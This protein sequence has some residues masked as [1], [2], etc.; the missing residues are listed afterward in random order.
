VSRVSAPRARRYGLFSRPRNIRPVAPPSTLRRRLPSLEALE[1]RRV[2]ANFSIGDAMIDEG[3]A[4]TT[5][6]RFTVTLAEPN[7]SPVSVN[8]QTA[9]GTAQSGGDDTDF[10]GNTGTLTFPVGVTTQFIDVAINGDL[11][12][13]ANETFT[14]ML[15]GPT[16]GATISDDTATGTITNDDAA[17]VKIGHLPVN[18]GNTNRDIE[19]IITLS[20]PVD[21]PVTVDYET[22]PITATDTGPDRDYI[23]E[24]GV[25]TFAAGDTLERIP[26][27]IVG[28]T[29][30]EQNESF[31][32]RMSNIQPTSRSVTFEN[33]AGT[34]TLFN[35]EGTPPAATLSINDVTETEGH[36]GTRNLQFTV[37]LANH[38]GGL[39]IL[40]NYTTQDQT[41]TAADNDY[42]TATGTLTFF[43]G[44]PLTQTVNVT[45]NGDTKVEAGT[46]TFNVVLANASLGV[47]IADDTG[48]GTITDDD[49]AEITISDV[50]A[51]EG[52]TGQTAFSF[53][54]ALSNPVDVAVSGSYATQNG[55]AE[56]QTGDND[57]VSESGTFTFAPGE[58]ETFIVV[59]VN[60]DTAVEPTENFSVVLS[61]L[62]TG[63]RNV[64][65]T[66]ATGTGTITSDDIGLTA[67]LTIDDVTQAESN[68]NYVFTLSL[69]APVAN[70]VCVDVTTPA[71]MSNVCIP[72]TATSATVTVNRPNDD[73]V[74][75]DET[76]QV[77]LGTVTV[78]GSQVTITDPT[79]VGT[80]EDD[81]T[82]TIT[83]NDVSVAEGDTGDATMTFTV[84]LSNPVSA[85]VTMT[86]TTL[87]GGAQD[88]TGDNDYQSQS[89]ALTIPAMSLSGTINIA[90]HGDMKVERDET[91][92][93]QLGVLTAG[94]FEG[95]EVNIVDS[96]GLGMITNDD[97]ATLSIDDVSQSESIE[98]YEFTLTLS[99]PVDTAITV[100]VMTDLD[101]TPITFAAGETTQTVLVNVPDNDIVE[102]DGEFEVTLANLQANGRN[103][104][105]SDGMGLGTILDDDAATI[106][107]N[108]VEQSES[109]ED[110]EFTI[111]LSQAVDTLVCVDV[112]T[113]LDM[114]DICFDPLETSTTFTVNVPDND[115]VEFDGFFDVTL[116]NVDAGGLPVT[117]LDGMGEG[118]ILDDDTAD[119]TIGD[120]MIVEGNSG[121]SML[122][123]TVMLSQEVDAIVTVTANTGG[124][125]A[126]AGTDYTAL[127]N[128]TI[129]F[130]ALSTSQTVSVPIQGDTATEPDETFIV[131]L[132]NL[133]AEGLEG[134]AVAI[135]DA[136]ATGTITNDD[137]GPALSINDVSVVEGNTGTTNLVFTVTLANADPQATVTV[138]VSTTDGTATTADNDYTAITAQTITFNPG[139]TT[140]QVNVAV[141]GDNRVEA[142]ETFTI[143][144][145]DATGAAVADAT[146]TGTITNDDAASI[147]ISDVSLAEGNSGTTTF[148]FTVTLNGPVDVPVTVTAN[149]ADGTALVA[150]NDYAALANS[151]ITFAAG[152][153]SQSVPVSVMGDIMPEANETFDVVLSNPQA[154]GRTVTLADATAMGTI[155]N[156]DAEQ[157]I[158]VVG[159]ATIVEG[160]TGTTMLTFT[161]TLMFPEEGTVTV[162]YATQDGTATTA[163]DDYESATGSL[164]LSST[165]P[166]AT[167][168]VTINGD[169]KIEVDETLQIMLSG[170]VGAVIGDATG[171]GTI[172]N[173]DD[174]VVS[175]AD[176]T[177][178]E[179]T[180]GT[181]TAMNF[182]VSLSQALTSDVT[183]TV[184]TADGTATLADTDY[185]ALTNQMV[186]IPAG[187]TSVPVTVNL[188]ADSRVEADEN[189]TVTLSNL[190]VGGAAD[191]NVNLGNATATGTITNDDNATISINDVTQLESVEDYTF[192]ITMSQPVDVAVTVD[193]MTDLGSMPITFAP[194]ETTQTVVVTVDDNDIVEPDGEF[195]VDLVNLQAAGRAVTI[196]DGEGVGTI[197]DDDTATL[198]INNVMQEESMEDYEFTLTLSKMVDAEVCVMVMTELDEVQVCFDPLDT[199]ETF[200][201]NIPDNDIVD[202]DG[203]FEVELA[204]LT[205]EGLP[206]TIAD[207]LGEGVILDDDTAV[208]SIDNVSVTEGNTGEEDMTFTLTL[209][210]PASETVT[211]T[212]MTVEGTAEDESGDNDF[213]SATGTVTFLPLETTA[214]IVLDA[215]G[216][217][218]IEPNETYTVVLSNIV[219]GDIR[220]DAITLSTTAGT[221]TGTILNDDSP[222]LSI[223]DATIVE[224]NSATSNLQ[225]TVTLSAAVS[226]DV[227]FDIATANGTAMSTDNDFTAVATTPLTIPAGQTTRTF[228][229]T[230]TGDTK[231]EATEN[232]TVNISNATNATIL[233]GAGTGT[234]TND[235]SAT[236]S[237]ADANVTEGN[238]GNA[239]MTFNVTLSNAVDRP[240]TITVNT[241]NGTATV[242][243]NDYTAITAGTVT[244]PAGQTTGTVT[245]NAT[246]DTRAEANENFTVTLSAPLV[247]GV[248]DTSVTLLD[249]TATGTINNDDAATVS[250]ADANVTEGNTGTATLSFT[251]TLSNALEQNVTMTVN[252][253]DGT[254]T[255]AGTASDYT[256]IVAGTATIP[257]GQTTAT[258]TVTV[259]GDTRVEANETLN[260]TLTN[261]L[262]GGV[263]NTGVTFSDASAIGTINND[264][265]ASLSIADLTLNEGTGT[266]QT[267]FTF[268]ITTTNPAQENITVQVSTTDGTATVAGTDYTAVTSQL[269][270]I[271]AGQTMT[272][273]TVN[274]TADSTVE[275]NE[276]FTV[277]LSNAQIGGATDATRVTI[278]DATAT[279]TI[280][281]DDFAATSSL[282]GTVFV[283]AN[284][285]GVRDANEP[286]IPGVTVTLSGTDSSS[287]SV[288]RTMLTGNDGS[289]SFG[290]LS[291]GTYSV[292]E[293]QPPAFMDGTETAGT[294][295]GTVG[296]DAISAITLAGDANATGYTF[297]ERGL[298]PPFVSK[299]LF[300]SS[301]PDTD[302]MLREL[303]ARSEELA[304][305]QS[306]A[307]AIRA[308]GDD[309]GQTARTISISDATITEGDTATAT[310]NFNVTM[311]AALDVPVSF[312]V[313]SANGSAVSPQDYAAIT[314][315]TVTLN[316]GETA[317]NVSVTITGDVTVEAAENFTVTLSNIQA[318]GR[319]VT[320]ADA[321]A[322]GTI[323]D[324]DSASF[325]ISDATP[326][327]EGN[328]GSTNQA[329]TVTLTGTVDTPVTVTFNTG[330]GT[331]TAGTDYT[332]R[333]TNETL[334]FSP[335]GAATQTINVSVTGDTTQEPDE[336][337]NVT[338]S[339]VQAGGRNVTISDA[340]GTGTIRNDDGTTGATLSIADASITEGNTGT[341]T[342]NFTVTLSQAATSTVTVNATTSNVTTSANDFTPLN[343]QVVTFNAGETSKQLSVQITP[344]TT[345]EQNESFTVTLSGASG[346]TITDNS[347]T[348]LI[349]NDDTATVSVNDITQAETNTGTTQFGFVVTLN[350][351][352]D[353]PVMVTLNTGGGTATAGTGAGADYAAIANQVVTFSPGATTQTVNVLVNGD[354]TNEANETFIVTLSNLQASGRTGVTISDA[355]GTG[356]INNDDT[357]G[358]SALSI[359]NATIA[360]P[361]AGT[362]TVTFNVNLSAPA[363]G[364]VTVNVATSNGTTTNDDLTPITSQVV[365]FAAGETTMPVTVTI[366]GDTLVE[367]DETFTVTLSTAS[368]ATIEDG[369]ATGTITNNDA[370]SFAISDATAANEGNTGSV[371]HAFTV[372]LTGTVDVPVMV[373]VNTGGGTATAGTDYTA[374]ANQ[375]LTFNP[376]GPATQTVNVSVTGDTTTEPD[377]TFNVVLSNDLPADRNIS[378]TD[379]TGTGT[380]TNDDGS[381]A[382]ALSIVD[383]A[384]E[385]PDSGGTGLTFTINLTPA[386]SA[387]VSVLVSVDPDTATTAD[388]DF[389]A[390]TPQTV[391][392]TVG[393]TSKTVSV[394]VNGDNKVEA[395][396][397]FTVMLG[398]PT[399]ATISD[400]TAMG[401]ITNDDTATVSIADATP[402]AEGNTGSLDGN[403][404]AITLSN[405]VDV[406]VSVTFNTQ[407][408]TADATDYEPVSD[409]LI[410]FQPGVVTQ[411]TS[412]DVFGDTVDEQ[413]EMYSAII[414]NVQAGGRPVTILDGTASATITDDDGSS[415]AGALVQTVDEFGN[416]TTIAS[417][418]TSTILHA[419]RMSSDSA[420]AHDAALSDWNNDSTTAAHDDLFAGEESWL[421]Q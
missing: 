66:D 400:G 279:A 41:A 398:S 404:F 119:V 266:A 312:T 16:G 269:V 127:T 64:T 330:G 339:N 421:S 25:I 133:L 146:G 232:F 174:A 410:T 230:I 324:N 351:T 77:M 163:D 155:E 160:D 173:D 85:D 302:D 260:V 377:E 126:T 118:T 211:V 24:S 58:T 103:V 251:V 78:G 270:T 114:T 340:T 3:N 221:G 290:Q 301:S 15:S 36:T 403:P 385:E 168:Q 51:V 331:A 99:R 177:L 309:G 231:V 349:N 314:N 367:A 262:V 91:L 83:I 213:H 264:D 208:I 92:S 187:Q 31:E 337:F 355:T 284:A 338:L 374:V 1:D 23:P 263:A 235:D 45:V 328:T 132:S 376:G 84:T 226:T 181:P 93:V 387:P 96:L 311:S 17:Q 113:D 313:N 184:N 95:V 259:T 122:V 61:G 253:S 405:P 71:G 286:G 291:P 82:A 215:H 228:N 120:A 170:A 153:T 94:G 60:G 283:D 373:T 395:N 273:V 336:T 372:T 188:S 136:T 157:P 47:T 237:I 175:I 212:Y 28:D 261:L 287:A 76:F 412:V 48:V 197:E 198:S 65:L 256:A 189:F 29:V 43:A 364:P 280:T 109:I 53:R 110:Y 176:V 356:T 54:V 310:L 7:G 257:A 388:N 370:A 329:F 206:V 384:I 158:L 378:I 322:T 159:D 32:F 294:S 40:V 323:T 362:T 151:V 11:K 74:E 150:N 194:G 414:S 6:L 296:N 191:P 411:N 26:V 141:T 21:V 332:A 236:I 50:T 72:G 418:E 57:Y 63:G 397:N 190:L 242:A 389:A 241:S 121:E 380:I 224:G 10:V 106:S 265:V 156:D 268:T 116:S 142:D 200:L 148:S 123:F 353:V 317:R 128:T 229:V 363:S 320:F 258:V 205:A 97:Q 238:T 161:V 209:S 348:G 193:A 204:D 402:N 131:T 267:S 138:S 179:G 303:N 38:P 407:P 293:T 167:V 165:S 420:G 55:T 360:E 207:A 220:D 145:A 354:V 390:F 249:A 195:V 67:A 252:T 73:I 297:S 281:N 341:S 129:T 319:T 222:T 359:T 203:V 166:T 199:T 307:D 90:I 375:V 59:D 406:A 27:T 33:T 365:N 154:T 217:T 202:A 292:T 285:N 124:G 144:L 415:Q 276:N 196:G 381:T 250:I 100:D 315:Q 333:T 369:T 394:T 318:T 22:F 278:G 101:T 80:T 358:Q 87:N 383:N 164:T 14:V 334:T 305:N 417:A 210:N 130:P 79:G 143:N 62:Q 240:V 75:E 243:D 2:L 326:A 88:Q 413:N 30:P 409:R 152:E 282:A 137:T 39:P 81:D 244:I 5:D 105:I 201:V 366:T 111:T 134:V 86:Y 13:E 327:N 321:T 350:G 239:P 140:K 392:F 8:W 247:G 223:G 300:L 12:V 272:T 382:M 162:N 345:V 4:A 391:N 246:G 9:P 147:S 172:T 308:G 396:E 19:F 214:T 234:I 69:S 70:E 52:N 275:P 361:N 298:L 274:V 371:N 186:T 295:G 344:D 386:A 416:V 233:D 255:A 35:D 325:A 408:G 112:A 399:G 107:I 34:A 42:E 379:A 182:T 44:Q 108:D 357:T 219:D 419:S 46:E 98:D 245:V 37:T 346:A 218:D 343:S 254:A 368:G 178:A 49:A 352:V 216:D 117:I 89:S 20:N 289:F 401:T 347:A 277:T 335:G 18:E 342:L 288:S 306:R 149:T 139:E 125:D 299:R 102:F 171:D 248:A 393:E 135:T 192:T 115:I 180:A 56:D 169:T 304:G 271:P 104:V 185:T 316:P 68:E 183:V 227:T 225:F